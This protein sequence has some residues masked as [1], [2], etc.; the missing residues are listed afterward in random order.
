MRFEPCPACEGWG[1]DF[2][3]TDGE[4]PCLECGGSGLADDEEE[5]AR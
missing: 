2:E 5:E 4:T 3:D 1:V